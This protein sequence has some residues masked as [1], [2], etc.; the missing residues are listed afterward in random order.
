MRRL[1][2]RQFCCQDHREKA[3]HAYSARLARDYYDEGQFEEEWLAPSL[4]PKKKQASF[5]PGSGLLL[6]VVA[7]V[8]VLFLPNRPDRPIAPPS[9]MPKVPGLSD[10]LSQ[11]LPGKTSL[12]LREDFRSDLRNW[13]GSLGSLRDG[14]S[15]RAD[16]VEVGRLR[17]WKPSLSMGD[18]NVHFEA[19]IEQKALGW[20]VRA[21]DVNNYYA[22]KI[23]IT[24]PDQW[25]G[26][27]AV[28]RAEILRYVVQGGRQVNK[29][30]L[31]IPLTWDT[32]A[33]YSFHVR[34]KGDRFITLV[35]DR[36]VDS[37]SDQRFRRGG[38]GFFADSG[39]H[40]SLKWVSISERESFF[41]RFLSFSFLISPIDL[42]PGRW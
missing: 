8:L 2:D 1:I 42:Q 25:E 36:V 39:E 32:K 14:W 20:A 22:T 10:R 23:Q 34:V 24:R 6:V 35:N 33:V 31:P 38:V 19:Q 13:Q 7:T 41:D 12:S 4:N 30:R 27:H 40:A 37:W 9:Y 15:K 28:A 21:S 26:N 17:L 18:Y 29:V 5:S 16:S 11:A 3:R